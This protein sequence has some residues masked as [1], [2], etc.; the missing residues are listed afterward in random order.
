[1]GVSSDVTNVT[2]LAR[3][4]SRLP[5]CIAFSTSAIPFV[6]HYPVLYFRHPVTDIRLASVVT[7]LLNFLFML[8]VVVAVVAVVVVV[9]VAVAV[10]YNSL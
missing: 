8:I 7:S 9:V 5:S 4:H 1:M 6:C 2:Q 3:K 10:I